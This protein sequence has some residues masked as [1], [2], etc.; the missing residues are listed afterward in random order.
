MR[1]GKKEQNALLL[2]AFLRTHGQSR[3]QD[4]SDGMK[5]SVN[6]LE[7]IARKLRIG[8][9]VES[10]RGPGGGYKLKNPNPSM[11]S[12]LQAMNTTPVVS[13]TDIDELKASGPVGEELAQTLGALSSKLVEKLSESGTA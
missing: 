12:V 10:V 11:W 3:I 6:F 13:Q 2:V 7:Q 5:L 9:V 4:M 8:G 1:L